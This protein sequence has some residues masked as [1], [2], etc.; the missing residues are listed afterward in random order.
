MNA[1]KANIRLTEWDKDKTCRLGTGY[2][3]WLKLSERPDTDWQHCF[4]EICDW[5]DSQQPFRADV[6]V[7]YVESD[8]SYARVLGD[9]REFEKLLYPRL[10]E[11]VRR[12]N[13]LFD[14]KKAEEQRRGLQL[15]ARRAED[16]RIIAELKTR[17]KAD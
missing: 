2:Q 4:Q 13:E 16:E 17:F 15:A 11:A 1:G 6:M 14:E 10:K 7:P 5:M 9:P 8:P 3:F 12:A